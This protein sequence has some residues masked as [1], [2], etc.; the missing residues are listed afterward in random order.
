MNKFRHLSTWAL[1]LVLAVAFAGCS[2]DATAPVDNPTGSDDFSAIDLN[3]PDGG[4]TPTDEDVA[5]GD[6]FLMQEDAREA[7]ELYTDALMADP[8][9]ATIVAECDSTR[10]GRPHRR[11]YFLRMV[12]GNLDGEVD[13]RTGEVVDAAR[14]DWSG[15]FQIDRGVVIVRRVIRFERGVDSVTRPRPDRQTVEWTSYTG[16]HFDGLLLQIIEPVRND[17]RLAPEAPNNVRM[18]A[19]SFTATFTTA[20]IPG[21]D[22]TA[23]V[24]D[25][26]SIHFTGFEHNGRLACPRGFMAGIWRMAPEDA[27]FEGGSF[28]GRWVNI[29]GTTRGY[30]M[31]RY[32]MNDA[33]ER[34]FRGKYITRNGK[35]GGFLRGSWAPG[36]EPGRGEFRGEW[37]NRADTR[38]GVLHG[39]YKQAG[40]RPG[41]FYQGRWTADCDRD[42]VDAL[43]R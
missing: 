30:M 43:E 15:A 19:G 20:D 16:G 7:E 33:G 34:V 6:A 2:D 11:S 17:E 41:G 40:D 13:E 12:W 36:D 23:D 31:G 21:L 8:E 35:F 14:A 9:V 25:M 28:R 10:D 24:G 4:L 18:K 5:F 42:A 1:V 38:E 22:R 32:G 29:L 27:A 26:G 3:A 39:R 37:V